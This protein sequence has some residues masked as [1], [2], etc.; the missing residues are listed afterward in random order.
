MPNAAVTRVG[1]DLVRSLGALLLS[2]GL[3]TACGGE[4]TEHR[5]SAAAP[6]EGRVRSSDG[7]EVAYDD[8][9]QGEKTVMLLHC[10]GCDRSFWKHQVEPLAENYRVVSLD[11]GGHGAT[12]KGTRSDW[13]LDRLAD[14]AVAVAEALDLQ[15]VILVGHS[16]G[17]PLALTVAPRLEGRVLGVVG[18]DSLHSGLNQP[19]PE[20]FEGF[21]APFVA[22]YAG[23]MSQMVDA[24]FRPGSDPAVRDWVKQKALAADPAT[25]VAIVRGY[26]TLDLGRRFR[27]AGVPIRCINAAPGEGIGIPTNIEGNRTLADFDATLIDGV[28][29]FLLLEKPDAFNAELLETLARF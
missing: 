10:W 16:L 4:R 21:A 13:S 24:M 29:H 5:P 22:D 2:V 27:E 9:G 12:G 6:R 11:L 26:R 17:G 1:R 23:T 7:I 14:D 15:R 3:L 8:R 18:V 19:K 20:D 28:G 25:M